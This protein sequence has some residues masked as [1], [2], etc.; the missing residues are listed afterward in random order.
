MKSQLVL[1]SNAKEQVTHKINTNLRVFVNR[2][3]S[4]FPPHWHADIEIIMPIDSPYKAICSNRTYEAE[5]GD[6][7]FICPA[8]LHEIFSPAPGTR[9]YIQADFS[10]FVRFKE[11]EKT[12][13]LLS[14]AL[15]IKKSACPPELYNEIYNCIASIAK[16]YYGLAPTADITDAEDD[17][18]TSYKELEPFCEL[19]IYSYL[20]KM[21]ALLGRNQHILMGDLPFSIASTFKNTISV[22]NVCAYISEHFTENLTLE[23]ISEYAGFSKFHFERIFSEYT[24]VT[25]YQYLQQMRINYAQTLLSN[26]E[27]SITDISDHAGFASCT[28]FT[29]A[30]KKYTGYPPSEY[31]MLKQERNRASRK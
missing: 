14:P 16:L 18:N 2:L 7:L 24:G 25:F 15:H 29:R 20:M 8:I 1:T 28:T 10:N 26:P 4:D 5:M 11:L 23:Q 17:E 21:I 19:E 6:I 9:L 27:L 31:R 13:R 30:F 12:F 3:H 22:S